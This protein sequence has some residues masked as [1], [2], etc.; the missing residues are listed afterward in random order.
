MKTACAAISVTLA[1][2]LCAASAMGWG[3]A[4][5]AYI[6]E[7]VNHK[8]PLL[9][10]NQVYGGM[11]TDVFNFMNDPLHPEYQPWLSTSVHCPECGNMWRVAFLPTAKALAYGF[12]S[13]NQ[14]WGADFYAHDYSCPNNDPPENGYI[15]DKA[16]SLYNNASFQAAL[17]D[18]PVLLEPNNKEFTMEL[19]RDVI[20][21]AV[22]ILIIRQ[23]GAIGAKVTSAALLRN[24][25]FPAMLNATYAGG[26]ARQFGL[27]FFEATKIIRATE[28]QFRQ[29]MVV[30]GQ[31]LALREV[32]AIPLISEQ[33]AVLA[34]QL[35]RINLDSKV[36]ESVI[37]L[38]MVEC[39]YD[40]M[41]AINKTINDVRV[42][43]DGQGII[44]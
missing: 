22:D 9:T 14:K 12:I 7:R 10:L 32:A 21:Y 25:E 13:H 18:Y 41:D 8:G 6:N 27:N 15:Q 36:I 30:Y 2:V 19:L 28:L 16:E 35:F 37:G 17:V 1:M 38:S 5:H 33:L 20:E 40:Y 31:I 24:P 39:A 44:Y 42:E 11:A 26:F 43:M 29:T 23:D 3:S 4:T 34:S